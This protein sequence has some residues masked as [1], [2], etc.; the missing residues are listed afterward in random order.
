MPVALHLPRL[1]AALAESPTLEGRGGTVGEIVS[2]VVKDHPVLAGKLVDTRGNP[3]PH[4]AIYLNDEDVR[5]LSG[6][7]TPV[8][9][10]DELT[11]V[12]AV[13]GG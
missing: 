2:N 5:A 10:K 11:F 6:W 12:V 4:V 1:L 3:Q 13:A 8:G 7:D 9:P